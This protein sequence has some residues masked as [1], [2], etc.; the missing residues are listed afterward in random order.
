MLPQL[1][2]S[3]DA[4][5]SPFRRPSWA[6][7]DPVARR[8]RNASSANFL[9]TDPLGY[10]WHTFNHRTVKL[11]RAPL[12]GAR[13]S[14]CAM[15]TSRGQIR[16]SR[17]RPRRSETSTRLRQ[18]DRCARLARNGG[19]LASFSPEHAWEAIVPMVSRDG[20]VGPFLAETRLH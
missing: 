12:A 9:I 11:H 18:I 6:Y 14:A 16:W 7:A 8:L 3:L 10:R 1:H 20:D 2:R 17:I 5:H 13:P 4:T 15:N 19:N